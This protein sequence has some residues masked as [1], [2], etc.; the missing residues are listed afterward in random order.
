MLTM[1]ALDA[2]I[3]AMCAEIAREILQLR[4][5]L[6]NHIH[7]QRPPLAHEHPQIQR[8]VLGQ[9]R[10]ALRGVLAVFESAP[11][12]R[13]QRQAVHALR[14]ILGDAHGSGC[15]HEN[16]VYEKDDRLICQDCREDI[17]EAGVSS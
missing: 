14:V 13:E 5:E 3:T 7:D 8:N 12:N 15:A 2:R 9:V 17:T 11:L 6:A 4:G 10:G 16:A 1:K